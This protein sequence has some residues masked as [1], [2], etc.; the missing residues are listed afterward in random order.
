MYKEYVKENT[1]LEKSEEEKKQELIVSIIKTKKELEESNKNFEYAKDELIDYYLYR[2]KANQAK[3]DYLIKK[4]KT[5]GIS[6]D[7]IN[8]LYIRKNKVV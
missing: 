1:I 5:N 4:A 8:E 6:I 3:L 2:I 7:R